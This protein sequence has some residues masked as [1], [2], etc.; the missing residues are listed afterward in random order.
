M[1]TASINDKQK[2][3]SIIEESFNDNP[4]I[5]WLIKNDTRRQKRI[6]ALAEYLFESGMNKKGVYLSSDMET[7]AIC[8]RENESGNPLKE[9][10]LILKL[11]FR[12]IGFFNALRILKR[13]FYLKSKRWIDSD[14]LYFWLIGSSNKGKGQGGAREI[15]KDIFEMSESLKLPIYMETSINQN[16]I[17]YERYGFK[18][19][20][21]WPLR[22]QGITMW[23]MRRLPKEAISL[24]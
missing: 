22:K 24:V 14:Y 20:H 5:K 10:I 15:Q 23:L 7:V 11:I 3:I 16:R 6:K 18:T 21:T 19:Y 9:L 17:V 12:A 2:V 13:Q 8:Y 4:S 1:K